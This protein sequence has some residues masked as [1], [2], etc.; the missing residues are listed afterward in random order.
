MIIK[1]RKGKPKQ[2]LENSRNSAL[3]AVE[4]YNKPNT[5]FRL[6]S[7][8]VLMIIAWTNLFHAYF[9]SRGVKYYYKGRDGKYLMVADEKKT[10]ELNECIKQYSIQYNNQCDDQYKVLSEPVKANLDFFYKNSE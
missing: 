10:W 9:Q 4:I 1:L 3:N 7:Y 2:I 5:R 8:I 6:E